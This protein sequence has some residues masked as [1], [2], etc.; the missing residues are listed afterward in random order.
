MSDNSRRNFPK[1]RRP[2]KNYDLSEAKLLLLY[3]EVDEKMAKGIWG[4]GNKVARDAGIAPSTF[5]T[6]L[7]KWREAGRPDISDGKAG[8]GLTNRRG[9]HNKAFKGKDEEE[10]IARLN[11]TYVDTHGE[12]SLTDIQLLATTFYRDKYGLGTRSTGLPFKA[13]IGWC[14]NIMKRH[15]LAMRRSGKHKPAATRG[16]IAAERKFV[17]DCGAA[18]IKFG[19]DYVINLDESYWRIINPILQ[20]VAHRG[21]PSPYVNIKGNL[22]AGMTVVVNTTASGRKLP[23]YIIAKGKKERSLAKYHLERYG[24]KVKGLLAKKGWMT[25]LLLEKIIEDTIIPYCDGHPAALV[26]DQVKSHI[27]R[28][29]TKL[30][31]DHNIMLIYLPKN[32]TWRRQPNDCG[33]LGPMKSTAKSTWRHHRLNDPSYKP[34]VADALA[35]MVT[36][37]NRV[38]ARTIRHAWRRALDMERLP[39]RTRYPA[40]PPLEQ[41]C[42]TVAVSLSSR[43]DAHRAVVSQHVAAVATTPKTSKKRDRSQREPSPLWDPFEDRVC[44]SAALSTLLQPTSALSSL[45]DTATRFVSSRSNH[46]PATSSSNSQLPA[47]KRVRTL[48]PRDPFDFPGM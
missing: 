43:P 42:R 44:E 9:G 21:N 29:I 18:I 23:S 33:V 19:A 15:I 28:R 1:K 22:K 2:Y 47:H 6:N 26:L 34:T 14:H 48:Y 5:N 31:S 10:F 45:V 46:H 32:I 41:V 12:L 16:E 13:S 24:N 30:C 17:A 7:N 27:S 39:T 4:I 36:A 25:Q 11:A 37:V 8:T 35:S 40:P 20:I 38:S 3:R